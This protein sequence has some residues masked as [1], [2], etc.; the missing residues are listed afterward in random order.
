MPQRSYLYA[1]DLVIWLMTIMF[2]GTPGR[3]YNVGSDEDVT[4]GDLAQRVAR[5]APQPVQVQIGRSAPA[6][7]MRDRYVP[8]IERARSELG[9]TTMIRLDDAIARTMRSLQP[10]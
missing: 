5:L 7:Q 3:I 1:A 10:R 4:I 8:S 9:L 2:D 6:S